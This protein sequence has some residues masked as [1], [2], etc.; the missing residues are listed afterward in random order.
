MKDNFGR[1]ISYLR[2]SITDKCNLRCKYCMPEKGVSLVE[3]KDVMT[4]EEY[5]QVAKVFKNL[6]ISKIRITGGE[7]LVK[8]GVVDLISGFKNIGIK[9]IAMTTNGILLG[10]MAKNLKEAGLTRV[11]ISLDSLQEDKYRGITRGGELQK[12]LDG[13]ESCKKYGITPV[14]LNTVVMKD[15]NIDEFRNFVD[16]T[17]EDDISVRFI[18]LMPI[19]EAVRYKDRFVS[20][21]ELLSLY[22]ELKPI[23]SMDISSPAKYYKLPKAKGNVGFINPMSCKFCGTCNRVRLTSK[24]QLLMCLHSNIHIE[25]LKPLREGKDIGKIIKDAIY[26]KPEAHHLLEGEYNST[27][28]N[29]IGG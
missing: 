6:G 22:P 10:D 9:E 4:I 11:N 17:K 16:L 29:E 28:M 27:D 13:I 15:V 2:I 24:G 25:L 8:K 12:V 19:G 14:K 3:H 18:E 21:D 20:N 23:D 5:I 7:P 26:N 1:D